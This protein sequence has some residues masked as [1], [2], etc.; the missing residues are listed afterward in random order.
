MFFKSNQILMGKVRRKYWQR[1]EV[2]L[3]L[4]KYGLWVYITNCTNYAAKMYG[5]LAVYFN[6]ITEHDSKKNLI[7][8]D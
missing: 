7:T 2:G 3:Q 8:D 6:T 4:R 5:R 1:K